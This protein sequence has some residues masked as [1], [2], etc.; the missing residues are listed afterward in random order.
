MCTYNPLNKV[1]G[2]AVGI[3]SGIVVQYLCNV[4]INS[5]SLQRKE[6]CGT[7]RRQW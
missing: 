1:N 3:V 5:S 6:I 7:G 2:I 4:F